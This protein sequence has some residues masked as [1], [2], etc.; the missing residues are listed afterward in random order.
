MGWWESTDGDDEVLL[1]DEPLDALG[2][3]V[4]SVVEAYGRSFRRRPSRAEWETLLG[5]ALG[6]DGDA[7]DLVTDAGVVLR[8]RLE[9]GPKPTAAEDD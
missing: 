4:R 2:D 6:G 9:L 8:V 1:G 3:A 7:V 5:L